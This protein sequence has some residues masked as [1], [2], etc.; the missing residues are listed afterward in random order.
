MVGLPTYPLWV[1]LRAILPRFKAW[2][3]CW[4]TPLQGSLAIEV[5]GPLAR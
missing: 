2:L 3:D 5:T 4:I 1:T